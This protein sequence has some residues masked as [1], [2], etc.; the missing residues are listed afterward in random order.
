[1]VVGGS[2]YFLTRAGQP[3]DAEAE[4]DLADDPIVTG[5]RRDLGWALLNV[6]GAILGGIFALVDFVAGIFRGL[7]R[8]GGI[9]DEET[10]ALATREE[11][12]AT[13]RQTTGGD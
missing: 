12:G 6:V 13:T 4:E 8:A 11:P 10:T 1:M 5:E 9:P 3:A 2:L 7:A